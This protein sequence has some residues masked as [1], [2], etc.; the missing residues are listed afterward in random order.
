M[1]KKLVDQTRL[2]IVISK[3]FQGITSI[4]NISRLIHSLFDHE[5]TDGCIIQKIAK[6]RQDPQFEENAKICSFIGQPTPLSEV[7]AGCKYSSSLLA[8]SSLWQRTS[9]K[10]YKQIVAENFVLI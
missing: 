6:K 4:T 1:A 9:P 10:C 3:E 7:L 8:S 2:K 5:E